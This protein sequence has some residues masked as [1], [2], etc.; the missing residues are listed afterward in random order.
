[1]VKTGIEGRAFSTDSAAT[2]ALRKAVHD[3]SASS[4]TVVKTYERGLGEHVK[5]ILKHEF[6]AEE[7]EGRGKSLRLA[8]HR[9]L[10]SAGLR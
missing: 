4:Y 8:A 2:T 9:A 1:M 5:V 6:Y 7:S 10:C 3:R